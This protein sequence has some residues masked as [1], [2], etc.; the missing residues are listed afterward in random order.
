M[1]FLSESSLSDHLTADTGLVRAQ[2]LRDLPGRSILGL[3]G[4]PGAGK[5]TVAA[6][7]ASHIQSSV[8]VGMDGFHLAHDE[9]I[10]LGRQDRKGAPDTFD[11][12]GYAQLLHRLV[13][14]TTNTV[15]CPEYRRTVGEPIAGAIAVDPEIQLVI[16]EG[17]YL[18]SDGPGWQR[19]RDV[20][21]EIW[22]IDIDDNLR[23]ERLIARHVATGKDPEYARAWVMGSDEAN[24]RLIA[25]TR[26]RAHY[27]YRH[28]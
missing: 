23:L 20:M 6:W 5:S 12:F 17:N 4:P 2:A 15:Y 21:E 13:C 26:N 25:R 19:A 9:L 3:T 24:A 11:A 22:Y 28:N 8:V 27:F 14:E 10:R 7:L 16:T 18:L 1:T